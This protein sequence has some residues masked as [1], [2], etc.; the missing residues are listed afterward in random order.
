ML[1]GTGWIEGRGC[2]KVKKYITWVV[3]CQRPYGFFTRQMRRN[4]AFEL[5][6][7]KLTAARK[8]DCLIFSGY[9][10]S[11]YVS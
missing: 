11:L 2:G 9:H 1:L 8:S 10:T 3:Q 7:G 6:F 4:T 5:N